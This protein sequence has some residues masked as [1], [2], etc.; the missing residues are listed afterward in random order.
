MQFPPWLHRAAGP[1][2][3]AA[4]GGCSTTQPWT[5]APLAV[6]EPIRYDGRAQMYDAGRAPDL[7]V[8]ASFSGG[9]SRAAA[10]AH[11]VLD[12]LD[13]VPF[14]WHGRRTTLTREIDLVIGVSGGSVAAAHLALHGP[15][16]HLA[17]FPTDFL[18]ADFQGH[19]IGTALSPAGLWRQS[20]PRFGRGQ[21]L[22]EA[23][24]EVLFAGATF[25]DLAGLADRP[26]LIVGATD[27]SSGAEF[28]FTSEQFE[29][30]C[31][32]IDRVPLSFAV[33]ASSSVPLLFSPLGVQNH[34]D[35]CPRPMPTT[36]ARP[37]DPGDNARMRLVKGEFAAL[38]SG[39]RRFIHLID[40]GVSDN[41]GT[42][43]I[44]DYVEQAGG[45]GAVLTMLGAGP[46]ATGRVLPRIVFVSVN[47]ERRGPLPLDRSGDVPS[48]LA[49]LDAMIYSGLGRQSDE[50]SLV[51]ADSIVQWRRELRSL[52]PGKDVD[53][54]SIEVKLS[55]L[56]DLD[57][58]ERVLA[59]PTAFRI[60]DDDV[61]LLRQAAQRSLRQS[62]DFGRFL[63]SVGASR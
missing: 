30:L 25:G 45:I 27:L 40:G 58:R 36:S 59:I 63:R 62:E 3:V 46:D 33:A 22:A 60:T 20:S 61:V 57:L 10:F 38:A 4:L 11:A 56:D 51:F 48:M 28:D 32:S 24:D 53:I 12:E 41:L 13:A 26:Y 21:L 15:R 5:N 9:G 50:T 39:N 7:L 43:R 16:D 52:S 47:S 14:T 42:R 55:D 6:D 37:A 18:K 49:V 2:V 34:R 54:F 17:R 31:S 29:L 44:A 1:I 35:G 8:V 19:L 23:F